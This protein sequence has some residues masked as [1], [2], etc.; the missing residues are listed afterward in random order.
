MRLFKKK[1]KRSKQKKESGKS[2]TTSISSSPTHYVGYGYSN[3]P[4]EDEELFIAITCMNTVMNNL[5]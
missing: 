3:D 1:E 5:L 4:K 2:S